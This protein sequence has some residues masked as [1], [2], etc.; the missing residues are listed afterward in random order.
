MLRR[1]NLHAVNTLSV[2]DRAIAKIKVILSSYSLTN[3]VDSL[4]RATNA[5]NE[6]SH[7]YL[8]GSAPNDVK[9]SRALQYE[10]DKSNGEDIK[11]NNDQ[12][13]KMGV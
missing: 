5:Y 6:K 3:W 8:M 1:K 2:F 13:R 10:L 12:W 7:S 9:N 11:H 4:Q